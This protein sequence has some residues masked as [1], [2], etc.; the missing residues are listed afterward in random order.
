VQ[1]PNLYAS[2]GLFLLSDGRID[3]EKWQAQG[4]EFNKHQRGHQHMFETNADA[5]ALLLSCGLFYPRYAAGWGV[6]WIIGTIGYYIGYSIKPGYRAYGQA[7]YFPAITAW[8]YGLY[9][10]GKALHYG[11]PF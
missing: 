7:F 2:P 10:A 6:M 4:I 9:C 1:I 5:Y 3:V 11:T 8:I